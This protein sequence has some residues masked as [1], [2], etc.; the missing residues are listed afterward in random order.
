[1]VVIAL[2]VVGAA[3]GYFVPRWGVALGASVAL[4]VAVAAAVLIRSGPSYA[5]E[6]DSVGVWVMTAFAPV[7]C[8]V[9]LL[10]RGRRARRAATRAS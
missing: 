7:G 9:V 8:G 1:M 2:L 10:V 5:L 4:W 3:L 6:P